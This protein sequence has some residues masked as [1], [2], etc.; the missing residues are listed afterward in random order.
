MRIPP[1]FSRYGLALVVGVV[2]A[3]I[4]FLMMYL[5]V[6]TGERAIIEKVAI[7][8]LEAD[9]R[10]AHEQRLS[11]SRLP[12]RPSEADAPPETISVPRI[13]TAKPAHLG[14][15]DLGGGDR[16]LKASGPDAG[17]LN[18]AVE[19]DYLPIVRVR[20]NYPRRA[21]D[22]G[23]TG[24]VLVEL[25]VTPSGATEGARV[26]DSAP[27]TVFDQ[28]ALAAARQFRYKPKVMNGVPVPV[29]GVRY[30]FTFEIT[31]SNRRE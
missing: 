5:I 23:I 30:K 18:Q 24:Y 31:K 2:V 29:S 14:T 19:G 21:L 12:P 17:A 8:K 22:K 28:A 27:G 4:I 11:Q 20:P 26:I 15:A 3:A 6:A 13:K 10:A 25:T 7:Y 9:V 1:A 16:P